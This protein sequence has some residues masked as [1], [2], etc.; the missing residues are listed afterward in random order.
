MSRRSHPERIPGELDWRRLSE[1]HRPTEPSQLASEIRRLRAT[2][3]T[4]R[5][6]AT[7]LRLDLAYVLE[8]IQQPD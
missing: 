4:A 8:V 2:G 1:Q 7:S 5:D 3:L 6:I